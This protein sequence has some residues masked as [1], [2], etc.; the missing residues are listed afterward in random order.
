ML[1]LNRRR[2]VFIRGALHFCRGIG[3]LKICWKLH[4][5]IVFHTVSYFNSGKFG[6]FFGI[7]CVGAWM[8]LFF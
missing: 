7:N 3:I 4:W 1:L 8:T 2:K 6:A 5:F